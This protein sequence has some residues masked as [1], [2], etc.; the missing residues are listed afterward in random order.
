M[1]PH[2]AGT[3]PGEILLRDVI[4]DDLP[5]LYEYQL[6]PEANAMAA[7]PARGWDAFAA[8]WT[9]ILGD[10]TVN[11][12]T[13]LIDGQVAGSISSFEMDGEREVGYW[14]GRVFWGKGVATTA[15]AAFLEQVPERPLYAHVA[16][17]NIGSIRVLQKCGFTIIGEDKSPFNTPDGEEIEEFILILRGG[18]GNDA[19]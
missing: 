17:H 8:H 4:A 18:D 15:L 13:V 12:K 10:E 6:D 14:F 19:D 1:P 9:K 2:Q 11:T 7:F 3:P 16:Q 5:L